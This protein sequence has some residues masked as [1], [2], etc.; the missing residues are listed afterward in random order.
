MEPVSKRAETCLFIASSIY[1]ALVSPLSSETQ[2]APA[3][4]ERCRR[5][6]KLARSR[7]VYRGRPFAP[8]PPRPQRAYPI[9][10]GR[11]AARIARVLRVDRNVIYY[12]YEVVNRGMRQSGP[13]YL[14]GRSGLAA[15]PSKRPVLRENGLMLR[16][17]SCWRNF[18]AT[19]FGL[20][21]HAAW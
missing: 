17:R 2:A 18:A 10:A 7:L 8:A 5:G 9:Q 11:G 16:P 6:L 12:G 14:R 13:A 19:W 3:W 15:H 20:L 1:Y 21:E 4:S